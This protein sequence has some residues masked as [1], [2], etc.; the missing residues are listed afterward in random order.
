[1]ITPTWIWAV[2]R[3]RRKPNRLLLKFRAIQLAYHCSL[4]TDIFPTFR[5][6]PPDCTDQVASFVSAFSAWTNV[7]AGH[8]NGMHHIY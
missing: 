1:M 6:F 4:A 2:R 3:R 5:D 8:G 7:G